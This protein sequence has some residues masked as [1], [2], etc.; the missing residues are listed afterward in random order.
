MHGLLLIPNTVLFLILFFLSIALLYY[1]IKTAVSSGVREANA[2]ILESVREIE[3]SVHEIK[4][5][6]ESS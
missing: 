3:K 6:K 1:I 4:T 2:R 5:K